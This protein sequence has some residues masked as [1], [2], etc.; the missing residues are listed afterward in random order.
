MIAS[1]LAEFLSFLIL[2]IEMRSASTQSSPSDESQITT[3]GSAPSGLSKWYRRKPSSETASQD[4][5][6]G[7]IDPDE[8]L[9]RALEE[10]A[11]VGD[12]AEEPEPTIGGEGAAVT[13][14]IT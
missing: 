3:S 11:F 9:T 6:L 4:S 14:P 13:T 2:A 12:N 1:Y 7:E 5:A 10:R 8:L